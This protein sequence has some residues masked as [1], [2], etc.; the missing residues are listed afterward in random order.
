MKNLGEAYAINGTCFGWPSK[1]SALH[2]SLIITCKKRK[3]VLMREPKSDV[4]SLRLT[5]LAT[6][7][8][9]V[10]TRFNLIL[11][12]H[13]TMLSSCIGLLC[14]QSLSSSRLPTYNKTAGNPR[15]QVSPYMRG[16]YVI[17][18]F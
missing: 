11:K 13:S 2:T 5:P 14:S 18:P 15:F 16:G 12:N 1:Q 4:A 6:K 10:G 17:S 9:L 7:Y 8:S 3:G